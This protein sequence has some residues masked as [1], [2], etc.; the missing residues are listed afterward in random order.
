FHPVLLPGKNPQVPS[1]RTPWTTASLMTCGDCHN[2]DSGPGAG[3]AGPAGPHGSIYPPL[4]ERTLS[5]ADSAANAGNSALCYKCHNFVSSTWKDH[6]RHMGY[7]S[8]E[9]CHDPHG[10]PNAHLINFNPTVI[11]GGQSY[12]STGLGHGSCTLSC[13]G[14]DHNNASY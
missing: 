13:H 5:F 1:L 6:V 9:N 8:C 11:G 3:G 4:L 2:N 12:K 7:T 10:S 14:K